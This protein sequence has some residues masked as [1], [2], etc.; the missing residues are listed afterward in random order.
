MHE[1]SGSGI[2]AYNTYKRLS[3]KYNITY[4]V[5][6]NSVEFYGNK[7]YRYEGI[8]ITRI[9][10]A[11]FIYTPYTQ[12][13]IVAKY[14]LAGKYFSEALSTI[15]NLIKRDYDFIHSFGNAS[16][17]ATAAYLARW[18]KKPMIIELC[19]RLNNPHPY[20]PILS[21]FIKP[22]F[23]RGKVFVAISRELKQVCNKFGYEDNVWCRPNP[24]D[25]NKFYVRD[26]SEKVQLRKKLSPFKQQD[27][28]LTFIAK[29]WPQKN[30]IFL[31]NV[32]S[33]LPE[34]YK[35]ILAGPIV[36]QGR[37]KERDQECLKRIKKKISELNLSERV[38]LLVEQVDMAEY[39]ALS[40][41]YLLPSW[42]EAL[43]T[44]MIESLG[45]GIP[46]IANIGESA[47]RQWIVDGE[48]GYLCELDADKWAVTIERIE[49][50]DINKQK[51]ISEDIYSYASTDIIDECYYKIFNVLMGVGDK[52][53]INIKQVLEI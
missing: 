15:I 22:D 35:L 47:F 46:V 45:C 16:S 49:I 12:N 6:C 25:I 9:S 3:K 24:V 36:F 34:K 17:V 18:L 10:S 20:M 41:V 26:I 1:Y 48:N 32:I 4:D 43:S 33:R 5:I 29:F 53:K 8:N 31:L 21:R 23:S 13:K 30:H 27:I 39:L 37:H 11:F 44:P 14:N 7:Q 38:H 50:P 42:N 2:R 40:D 19:N 51:K 52:G 28:V